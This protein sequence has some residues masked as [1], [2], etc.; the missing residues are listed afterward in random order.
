MMKKTLFKIHHSLTMLTLKRLLLT[1]S[2]C[3]LMATVNAAPMDDAIAAYNKGDYKEALKIWRPLTDQGN[4]GAQYNIGW[5]YAQGKGVTQDYSS[6]YMWYN[7]A[8]SAGLAA[9]AKN[10]DIIAK[11][12]TPQQIEK[13]KDMARECQARNFKG[14]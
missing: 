3:C 9:G 11:R 13:A 10:R 2:M 5:M 12:M 6:A 14:C 1:I 8:S 7:L 4:A